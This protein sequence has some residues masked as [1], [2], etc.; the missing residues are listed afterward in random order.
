VHSSTKG[1]E[2]KIEFP[3]AASIF[4][5]RVGPGVFF[6]MFRAAIVGLSLYKGIDSSRRGDAGAPIVY[7]GIVA[8]A[9]LPPDG[10]HQLAQLHL[11]SHIEFLNTLPLWVKED[12]GEA[13]RREVSLR[14]EEI[15]LLLME[16]AWTVLGRGNTIPVGMILWSMVQVHAMPNKGRLMAEG[17][18]KSGADTRRLP[19][20]RHNLQ[21]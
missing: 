13:A 2:G 4:M 16:K 17:V 9:P 1:G 7:Q 11:R 21:A 12:L 3:G 20:H 8:K 14:R 19:R 18:V 6:A 5:T 15:K 10:V